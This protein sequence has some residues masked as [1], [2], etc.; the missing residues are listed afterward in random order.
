MKSEII[1]LQET[2]IKQSDKH[3]LE[4]RKLGKVFSAAH[5]TKKKRGLVTYVREQIFASEDG[6]KL[7]IEIQ[8][9]LQKNLLVNLYAP[10]EKQ[11][12]F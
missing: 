6:R 2:H 7:M 3:L 10:N 5:P 12:N 9:G 4:C 11:D 8:R 1:C